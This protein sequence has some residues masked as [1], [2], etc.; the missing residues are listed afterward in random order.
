MDLNLII[1]ILILGALLFVIIRE[2]IKNEGRNG[3]SGKVTEIHGRKLGNNLILT[4][5]N[6]RESS[7]GSYVCEKGVDATVH[8]IKILKELGFEHEKDRDTLIFKQNKAGA[9]VDKLELS[10]ILVDKEV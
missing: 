9:Y 6:G 5:Y 10:K 2:A 8:L 3:T 7:I 4:Y 1:A